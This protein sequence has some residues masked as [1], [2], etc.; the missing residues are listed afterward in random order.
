MRSA[1]VLALWLFGLAAP[2][3]AQVRLEWKPPEPGKTTVQS[4]VNTRQ[5][6]SLPGA[7]VETGTEVFSRETYE[8]GKKGDD[9]TVR[10][11]ARLETLQ[12]NLR[13]AGTELSF[14][15][16]DPDKEVGDANLKPIYDVYRAMLKLRKTLVIGPD[17]KVKSAETNSGDLGEINELFKDAFEAD[18]VKKEAEQERARLPDRPV[19]PGDTWERTE[20]LSMPGAQNMHFKTRYR[21]VGTVEKGGRTLHR[22][23]SEPLSVTYT[24]GAN[25]NIPVEVKKSKL[26]IGEGSKGEILF[27]AE[28]G[29]VQEQNEELRVK[30]TMALAFGGKEVEAK[31]DLTIKLKKTLEP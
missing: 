7:D 11:V 13:I 27:D 22:I 2:A 5:V 29:R 9:G 30:G 6:L 10:V 14:S 12:S 8:A 3:A 26:S 17:G 21:Y 28:K 15:S 1:C 16:T 31:L 20:D 25:P 19:K 18:R 23:A 4:E 24:Q